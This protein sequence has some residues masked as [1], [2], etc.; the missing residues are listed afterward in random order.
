MSETPVSAE[1]VAELLALP[2][3]P[4]QIG[5]LQA[6]ALYSADGM[7]ALLAYAT[8]NAQPQPVTMLALAELVAAL[9]DAAGAPPV[10]PHAHYLAA[11]LH[12]VQG[13][14]DSAEARIAQAQQ[15]FTDLGDTI[16]AHRTTVGLMMVLGQ[17]GRHA[18]ALAAA[19]AT[20]AAIGGLTTPDA[21]TV[22]AMI[23]QNRG[24]IR[25]HAG[26]Y[27][28]ALAA[29]AAAEAGYAAAGAGDQQLAM[30]E[31]QGV[32]LLSQGRASDA[33]ALF[34]SKRDAWDPVTQPLL[35]GTALGNSGYAHLQAG[36]FTQSLLDLEAAQA[37][38]AQAGY[39][40]YA[41]MKQ[42]DAAD[43]YLA[44]NLYPEAIDG[45][46]AAAAVLAAA[47]MPYEHGRALWGWGMALA[48]QGDLDGAEAQLL[49]AEALFA[50]L[51]NGPLLAAVQLALA[52]LARQRGATAAAA[53][54]AMAA[55]TVL[56][57]QARATAAGA[58]LQ[59]L[60]ALF[61][62]AELALAQGDGDSAES[63]LTAAQPIVA[64]LAVPPLRYRLRYLTGRL[65]RA[66]A[67]PDAAA[68]ALQAAIA[69]VES[70]RGTLVQEALRA[71]YLTDKTA[72][73]EEL[74]AL[75][76]DSDDPDAVAAAFAVAEQ[77]KSRTLVERMVGAL[78]E[79][80]AGEPVDP[81][82]GEIRRL[83]A[84]L[85]TLYNQLLG[86]QGEERRGQRTLRAI[87]DQAATLERRLT[88]LQ[89]RAAAAAR[90]PFAVQL[91]PAELRRHIAPDMTVVAY[92]TLGDEI[93]AFVYR[94]DGVRVARGLVSAETIHDLVERLRVQWSRLNLGRHLTPQHIAQLER[95]AR[96]VLQALYDALV[97]PLRDRLVDER[98]VFVPHGILHRIPFHALHD[99]ARYLI[100]DFV[101]SYAPSATILALCQARPAQL[102]ARVALFGVG[103]EALV[104]VSAETRAIADHFPNAA[105]YLEEAAPVARFQAVAPHSDVLHVACHGIFR[106]DNPLFSALRLHD[107]WLTAHDI[108]ALDLPGSLVTL[109]ACESGVSQVRGGDEIMGLTRAFLGAGANT[110]VVTLWL[111][112]DAV[113]AAMMPQWYAAL[114]TQPDR[115]AALRRAQLAVR[116]RFPH[117]F[118]WAPFV[119][120]GQR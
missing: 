85:N 80:L 72:V 20:L 88:Q 52:D 4:A 111:V 61:L 5:F 103:D 34:D 17:A 116:D 96:R 38:H 55:A 54:A 107:G 71:A 70:M 18:D 78:D 31:N 64:E 115:A 16:A 109:S 108:L 91:P 104:G 39:P 48:A 51:G 79:R 24:I 86:D 89:R 9:S 87:S 26:D 106:A 59:T 32:L 35:S 120:V 93:M 81:V 25:R 44:L 82:A 53:P 6:N 95:S 77:A 94:Q 45:Y 27:D 90:D 37:V 50:A 40:A 112:D 117:P 36:N 84:D 11:R 69:D 15:A 92:H 30:I 3:T 113:A 67:R 65:R 12:A 46:S 74:I 58:P 33:L 99:G 83:R 98:L 118:Y 97:A 14:V 114:A 47:D 73:Y 63:A 23:H 60:Y 57:Q 10:T 8:A 62:L 28:G 76:L 7:A 56:A 119:L 2:D 21:L 110:L 105:S 75:Y 102:G 1:L 22:A 68:T 42:L 43:A 49:A 13:D 29:Y 100:D 66:Q 19:D 41:A 101:I